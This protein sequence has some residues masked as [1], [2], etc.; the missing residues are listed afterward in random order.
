MKKIV[1]LGSTGSIGKQVLNVVDRNSDNLC[2]VGLSCRANVKT[3]IEQ[4]RKYKVEIASCK[5]YPQALENIKD[6]ELE[7]VK[8]VDFD[9]LVAGLW[10]N[11]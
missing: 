11:W 6:N 4:M 2:I 3:L 10:L 9:I 7:L 8:N 1:V 5:L